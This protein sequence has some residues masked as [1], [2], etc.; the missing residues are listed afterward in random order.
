MTSHA[1]GRVT[2]DTQLAAAASCD[3][4]MDPAKYRVLLDNSPL[5]LVCIPH[6]SLVLGVIEAQQTQTGTCAC[7]QPDRDDSN[8]GQ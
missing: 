4:C 7:C 2:I 1:I 3:Q 8:G 6:V 5:Y